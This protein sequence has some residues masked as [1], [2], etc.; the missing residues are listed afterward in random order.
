M[1]RAVQVLGSCGVEAQSGRSLLDG[2]LP[3]GLSATTPGQPPLAVLYQVGASWM[4]AS[5]SSLAS[6]RDGCCACCA[7]GTGAYSR[8]A[9]YLPLPSRLL[10]QQ[11]LQRRG[12]RV[13]TLPWFE[14]ALQVRLHMES[15]KKVHWPE[16]LLPC[17]PQEGSDEQLLLLAN[18]LLIAGVLPQRQRGSGMHA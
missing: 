9:P 5:T 10:Q 14:W 12:W 4:D 16:Q 2:A 8:T 11:L 13:L 3:L 17:M 7:Q 6:L 18:K 15:A 1:L